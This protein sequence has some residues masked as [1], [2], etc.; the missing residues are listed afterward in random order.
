MR[1]TPRFFYEWNTRKNA[2]PRL[3]ERHGKAGS[4]GLRRV[5]G[6]VIIHVLWLTWA[7]LL[8]PL[9]RQIKFTKCRS[10]KQTL[11]QGRFLASVMQCSLGSHEERARGLEERPPCTLLLRLVQSQ[12]EVPSY[13]LSV[14]QTTSIHKSRVSSEVRS[15]APGRRHWRSWL[16]CRYAARHFTS[17]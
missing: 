9:R 6:A 12:V 17:R 7:S 16:G 4:G 5:H 10:E 2:V 14:K 1:A 8:S 15:P 3:T 13:R 11:V